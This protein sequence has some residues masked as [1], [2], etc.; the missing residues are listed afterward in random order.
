LQ[1]CVR[2]GRPGIRT[3]DLSY[4]RHARYLLGHL[5]SEKLQ[6]RDGLRFRLGLKI[7][8]ERVISL[9]L[10]ARSKKITNDLDRWN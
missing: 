9:D 1:R 2:I 10:D 3:L 4:T 6:D 7:A 8:N 5:A